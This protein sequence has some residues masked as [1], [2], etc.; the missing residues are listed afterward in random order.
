MPIQLWASGPGMTAP[1]LT[2]LAHLTERAATELVFARPGA[3]DG[4]L[5]INSFICEMEELCG[6]LPVTSDLTAGIAKGR[7]LV[8]GILTAKGFFT[9]QTLALLQAWTRWMKEVIA[10]Q[11]DGKPA[12]EF[13]DFAKPQ[14]CSEPLRAKIGADRELLTE[15][16]GEA[17]EHL[18]N[19]EAGAL[20]LERDPT[21]VDALHAIFR[22]FHS[23]KGG[24]GFLELKQVSRLTH[25][26]E[27]LL[28][29]A[30]T[31]RTRLCAEFIEVILAA[32]E[33][34][35]TFFDDVDSQ[36]RGHGEAGL[37]GIS[38]ERLVKRIKEML[39]G[40]S[41]PELDPTEFFERVPLTETAHFA[42]SATHSPATLKVDVRKI[43][44]LMELAAELTAATEVSKLDLERLQRV[45]RGLQKSIS[46]LRI[47]SLRATFNKMSRLARDLAAREGKQIQFESAGE[48]LELD[49]AIVEPL[50]DALVHMIRN[51]VDHAIEEP[52]SRERRGKNATGKIS[53]SAQ[54]SDGAL[55]VELTDD[56]QGFSKERILKK[57]IAQ[58]L[59]PA[60]ATLTETQVF[61]LI[62]LPGF[63]TAEKITDLSG[64][65]VGMDV[66][67]RNITRLKGRIEAQ[68]RE[69]EGT[70]FKIFLPLTISNEGGLAA[71]GAANHGRWSPEF[72]KETEF[73]CAWRELRAQNK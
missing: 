59:V 46:S 67:H 44:A 66:V 19:V 12:P 33:T 27:S 38:T 35:R 4:L 53:L 48:D 10:A 21:D 16:V 18:Q 41:G 28:D 23:I 50:S 64:R 73:E 32:T 63:S 65:G 49:R 25:E 11:T 56:G 17:R 47:V 58:R 68:S 51:A 20:A 6:S 26:V 30:R 42:H 72:G 34:L 36:L 24:A 54:K 39:A 57:A 61:Q 1:Q 45:A 14:D 71:G 52:Q 62:F 7:A 43:D 15:F 31:G 3:D 70:T 9:E 69:G 5:P 60:Q 8:D 37:V 22:A 29:S 13:I 55:I 40:V 2:A